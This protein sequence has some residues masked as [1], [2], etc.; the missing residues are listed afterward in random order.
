VCSI[1]KNQPV[2]SARLRVRPDRQRRGIGS[3]LLE[4]A[5]KF[6]QEH[7]YLK[8]T[9]DT[10]MDHEPAIKLFEKFAS[11]IRAAEPWAE[12]ELRYFYL[13]LYAGEGSQNPE[14]RRT[15]RSRRT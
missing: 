2:K 14:R 10:Y 11:A 7:H 12:K 5:L 1:T 15:R 3:R 13:D 4:V 6:C 9:L 8:V